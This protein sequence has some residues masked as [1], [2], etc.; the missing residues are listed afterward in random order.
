MTSSL[1]F[2][3]LIL[4]S[5]G[6]GFFIYGKKQGA[7]VPLV[8]GMLLMVVPYFISNSWLLFAAGLAL[9]VIPYFIRI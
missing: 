3:G 1:L 5:V 2:F 7:P 6:T 8:C 4:G 9:A